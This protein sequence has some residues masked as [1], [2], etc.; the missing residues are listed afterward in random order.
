MPTQEELNAAQ[1]E[2][3]IANDNYA[4]L[5]DRYN[6]YQQLFQTYASSSPEIQNRAAAAMW[7][8]LEDYYQTQEKMK[9]A[10]ERIAQAQNVMNNYNEIIANQPAQQTTTRRVVRQNPNWT[11]TEEVI[12]EPIQNNSRAAIGT[13]TDWRTITTDPNKVIYA[14]DWAVVV[15]SSWIADK[16]NNTTIWYTADWRPIKIQK[17]IDSIPVETTV[18]W[19]TSNWSPI[20][21]PAPQGTTWTQWTTIVAQPLLNGGPIT[22]NWT[23]TIGWPWQ[24]GTQSW[25]RISTTTTN[26]SFWWA[27]WTY[28]AD[29]SMTSPNWQTKVYAD[30]SISFWPNSTTSTPRRRINITPSTNPIDRIKWT[31]NMGVWANNTLYNVA[32]ARVGY[33]NLTDWNWIG[34]IRDNLQW[35]VNMIKGA[36]WAVK[37]AAQFNKW[38]NQFQWNFN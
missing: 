16:F 35:W 13:T 38:L 34:W 29:G 24:S 7:R 25:W 20:Y 14:A 12:A 10:E 17:E 19:Y 30:W 33:N 31:Y 18:A 1:V 26:N 15:K 27:G 5:A 4:Q 28:N 3:D 23:P 8:A 21:W 6:K 11:I 32:K 22:S 2:L 36:A 9:A 37:W